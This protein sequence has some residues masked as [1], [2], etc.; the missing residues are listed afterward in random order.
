VPAG[1]GKTPG[2]SPAEAVPAGAGPT[3]GISPAKAVPERTHASA[4]AIINRFMDCSPLNLRRCKSFYIG[5]NR[6]TTQETLQGA[7]RQTNIRFAI[8]R[9]LTLRRPQLLMRTASPKLDL[10]HLTA[11]ERALFRCQTALEFKDKGDYEHAQE[12]MRPLWK[13]VG[14]RPETTGLHPSVAAEVL[15]SAGIL[16]GWI[17]SKNEV[18]EANDTARD[19]I[20]ESI[21]FYESAGDVT[22]VAAARAE[23]AYCYW[24]AGALDEARIMFTEALQKL[25]TEGNTRANAL[26][27]IVG[28]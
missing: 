9:I 24:R 28:C 16:T 22:K 3:A 21:T 20:T 15:L 27:W 14:E 8:G 25:T 23:L 13:G 26:F 18:K 11:N 6:T 1:A 2:I 5:L 19:L 7:W 12:V 4:I 10:S 17:G